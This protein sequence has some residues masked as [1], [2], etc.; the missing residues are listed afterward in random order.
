MKSNWEITQQ[1]SQY[2]FDNSVID[3]RWDTVQQLG[4]IQPTWH[5]ELSTATDAFLN[6]LNNF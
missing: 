2:H 5:A 6:S 3:P 1:R 4:R